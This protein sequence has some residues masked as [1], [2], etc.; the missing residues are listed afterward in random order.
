MSNIGFIYYPRGYRRTFV[1]D[2]S[3]N[4]VK[5]RSGTPIMESNG[6]RDVMELFEELTHTNVDTESWSYV[7][8][9]I[10]VTARFLSSPTSFLQLQYDNRR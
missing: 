9:V 2:N 3:D 1:V 8:R 10:K 6:D 5:D 4:L 7:S